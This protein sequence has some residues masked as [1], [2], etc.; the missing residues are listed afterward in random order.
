MR[1]LVTDETSRATACRGAPRTMTALHHDKRLL[2]GMTTR[3]ERMVTLCF[4]DIV[5]SCA[6]A[7][8]LGDERWAE[9][10]QWHDQTIRTIVETHGGSLSYESVAGQGTTFS[11]RLKAH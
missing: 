7:Q 2:G 6:L 1:R 3:P 9:L 5:G 11:I 10:L 4:T 8:S